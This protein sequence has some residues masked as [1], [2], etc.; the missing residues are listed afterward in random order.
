MLKTARIEL[1]IA[2]ETKSAA[3]KKAEREGISLAQA[4]RQLLKT[5]LVE[6]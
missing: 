6:E 3:A 2:P 4:I 5:W 1:V